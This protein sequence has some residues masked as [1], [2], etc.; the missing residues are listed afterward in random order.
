SLD[1]KE[2][3]RHSRISTLSDR[4][5]GVD[6]TSKS[7]VSVSKMRNVW[8]KVFPLAVALVTG[9]QGYLSGDGSA[10]NG[11]WTP[12]GKTP[13]GGGDGDGDSGGDGDLLS[14]TLDPGRTTLRRLNRAEYTNTLQ[15]L[16]GT[17][18]R[19]GDSLPQDETVEGLDSV[20]SALSFALVHLE[21]MEGK[22]KE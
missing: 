11:S 1:L 5:H 8:L 20:G 13:G 6:A 19:P 17:T 16:L 21:T 2:F 12:G 22:P 10:G 14:L 15:D 3:W 4:L 18:Q 7:R 9:C